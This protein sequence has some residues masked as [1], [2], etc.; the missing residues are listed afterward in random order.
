MHPRTACVTLLTGLVLAATALPVR[1]DG[2]YVPCAPAYSGPT[3]VTAKIYCTAYKPEQYETYVTSY[4]C[5]WKDQ[6]YKAYRCETYSVE[7]SRPVTYYKSVPVVS[8]V[9]VTRYE[10]QPYEVVKDIVRYYTDYEAYQSY[11]TRCV[12]KG[13]YQSYQVACCAPCGCA[14]CYSTYSC[15][16]P[17]YEYVQ[18]PY[19]A[20]KCVVKSAPDKVKYTA[21]KQ[22]AIPEKVKVTSYKME[23]YTKEEK[24]LEYYT[25]QVPYDV[26]V[27]VP[28]TVPVQTKVM[29]T[30]YV[31]YQVEKEVT[32]C[33]PSYCGSYCGGYCGGYCH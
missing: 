26:T 25:K 21:Y 8:E 29:A 17:K 28:Y 18:V 31:P 5:A 6:T 4:Q 11:Y 15:W 13:Y 20:Y 32:Y 30:R 7:K 23:S 22:V 10:C 12:D 19:T 24:Y 3:Y 14:P 16:V 27:K 9:D 2:C 1:A 33:V